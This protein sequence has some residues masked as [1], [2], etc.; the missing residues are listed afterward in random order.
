MVQSQLSKVPPEMQG[1]L[2][3]LVEEHPDV[4]MTL[5]KDLEAEK[6]TGKSDQDAFLAVAE[7][8]KETLKG[9]LK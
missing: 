2:M 7:K 5:A 3:K 1:M 6:K 4:L 8:H 9:I